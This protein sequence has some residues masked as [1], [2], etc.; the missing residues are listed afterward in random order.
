MTKS[1]RDF[2]L[3]FTSTLIWRINKVP[4]KIRGFGDKQSSCLGEDIKDGI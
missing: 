2:C 1:W 4:H 3:Q